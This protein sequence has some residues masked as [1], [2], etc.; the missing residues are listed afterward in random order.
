LIGLEILRAAFIR[1]ELAST[2]R[3]VITQS[4]KLFS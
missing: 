4:A 2:A 1:E 3:I